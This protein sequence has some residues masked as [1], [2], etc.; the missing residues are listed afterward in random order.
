MGILVRLGFFLQPMTREAIKLSAC[1][2]VQHS[3]A[4]CIK[5][6]NCSSVLFYMVGFF[7]IWHLHHTAICSIVKLVVIILQAFTAMHYYIDD[8]LIY[9]YAYS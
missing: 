1:Y 9:S 5:I 3:M 8:L 6:M 4:S 2:F 7:T